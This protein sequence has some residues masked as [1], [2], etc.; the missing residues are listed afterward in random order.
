MVAEDLDRATRGPD[1]QRK[2][3]ASFIH[4]VAPVLGT[5]SH[6]R[7]ARG[8]L[9]AWLDCWR[10]HRIYMVKTYVG[11]AVQVPAMLW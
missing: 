11:M 5:V 1:N 9:A 4:C 6:L 3:I 2:L 10:D 8:N 7:C